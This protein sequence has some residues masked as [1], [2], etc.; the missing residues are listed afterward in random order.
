ML[1]KLPIAL[2]QLRAGNTS[3]YFLNEIRQIIYSLYQE[4]EISKKVYNNI[5]NLINLLNRLGTIFMNSVNS[6]TH[7]LHKLL[8]NLSDKTNLKRSDKY[9]AL[10]NLSI[11]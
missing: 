2:A 10:S 1:Q 9:V 6:K 3:E 5:T 8:L 11:Y 4:K 7:D